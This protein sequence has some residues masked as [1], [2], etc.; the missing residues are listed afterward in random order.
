VVLDQGSIIECLLS[1]IF[2][3]L[4]SKIKMMEAERKIIYILVNYQ[5]SKEPHQEYW[6]T[7]Q[8]NTSL[9]SYPLLSI[10]SIYISY[11][12]N[13]DYNLNL[14]IVHGNSQHKWY[15]YNMDKLF[16]SFT[17]KDGSD[18]I[19]VFVQQLNLELEKQHKKPPGSFPSTDYKPDITI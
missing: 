17:C 7:R 1:R 9:R 10:D 2:I 19:N 8:F 11:K 3:T 14:K 13:E 16:F 15:V 6:T 18:F 12:L 4:Q 5:S